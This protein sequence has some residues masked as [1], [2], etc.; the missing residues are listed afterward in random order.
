MLALIVLMFSGC[1]T[2]RQVLNT[3]GNPAI[4][5]GNLSNDEIISGLKEALRVSTDTTTKKLSL[6]NG[7]F[8]DDI[9][10]I[11]KFYKNHMIK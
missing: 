7:F 6:L 9:I 3:I 5:T 4:N 10:K 2:A 8:G 1:D 11:L